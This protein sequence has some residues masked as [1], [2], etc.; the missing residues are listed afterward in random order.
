M[1]TYRIVRKE[2]LPS[3]RWSGGTTTELAIW[4][5]EAVY[6]ERNFVW[7]VSSARV[8]AEESDFTP[9]PGVER[10]LMILEGTLHLVHE[11]H[12]EATLG[13]FEQDNFSGDWRTHSRGAV[14]DFNLMTTCAE[15]R[16]QAVEILPLT[17]A[18]LACMPVVQGWKSVSE[19]FYCLTDRIGLQMP[20]SGEE[21]LTKGDVMIRN[22]CGRSECAELKM[23]NSTDCMARLVRAVIYHD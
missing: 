17:E 6:A 10:C 5:P 4:P 19:V 14:T 9:L 7:R 22:C 3:G 20:D 1:D 11:G 16:V 18:A 23:V 15:G 13:P 8:E 2:E 12:Y 21:I